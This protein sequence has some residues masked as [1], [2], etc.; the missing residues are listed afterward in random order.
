MLTVLIDA[1]T[2]AT[3]HSQEAQAGTTRGRLSA[4]SPGRASPPGVGHGLPVRRHRR[5]SQAQVPERDRRAQPPLPG[6]P[7]GQA[8]QGQGCGGGAGGAHEPL[9]GAG[10]HPQRQRPG[11]QLLRRSPRAT[12]RRYG[13]GAR[14]APPPAR[15]TSRRD[16]HGRTA[17]QSRSMAASGMSSSTPSCS[18]QLR[19]L[20]ILADR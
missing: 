14:P 18:P 3:A 9:P 15:P 10:L 7:G 20:L 11:V 17:L 13:T 16:P 2:T 12:P 4:A 5:R 19:R 6:D 1:L 8:V